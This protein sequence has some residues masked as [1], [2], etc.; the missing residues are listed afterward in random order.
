MQHTNG[1][2]TKY[3]HLRTGTVGVFGFGRFVGEFI[4]AGTPLGI[5]GDIG[6]ASGPHVH[7]EAAFLN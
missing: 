1:E 2:W 3:T 4:P 5:E 7:F 6:I